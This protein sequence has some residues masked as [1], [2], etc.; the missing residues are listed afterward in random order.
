MYVTNCGSDQE[1]QRSA[2]AFEKARL[3]NLESKDASISTTA[4]A[5][6]SPGENNGVTVVFGAVEPGAA[7]NVAASIDWNESAGFSLTATVTIDPNL[8]GGELR[9]AVGHE[10]QHVLD[11]QAFA[12]TF[13][14]DGSYDVSKNLTVRQTET[15]AYGITQRILVFENANARFAGGTGSVQLGKGLPQAKV[16][17]AVKEIIAGPLYAGKLDT[18]QFPNYAP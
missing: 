17:R 16:D 7:A 1:C 2:T 12:R 4:A 15:N 9:A 5:Y 13:T 18:R 6:G 3:A 11:A 10:G 14:A 8:A